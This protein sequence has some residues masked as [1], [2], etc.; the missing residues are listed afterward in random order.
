MQPSIP[1]SCSCAQP[2]YTLFQC[3]HRCV[4]SCRALGT[5]KG[6]EGEGMCD[7]RHRDFRGNLYFVFDV[8]FPENSFLGEDDLKVRL[9][10]EALCNLRAMDTLSCVK[11]S[12][13]YCKF[14]HTYLV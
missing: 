2:A 13:W 12:W 1:L 9:V 10:G 14:I 7:T 8:D 11:D 4:L 3:I 6:I 5:V